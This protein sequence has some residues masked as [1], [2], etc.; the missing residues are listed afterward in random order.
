[1]TGIPLNSGRYEDVAATVS[2][3]DLRVLGQKDRQTGTGHVW[4]DNRQH[5]WRAVVNGTTISGVS[6]TV[7]IAMGTP[8][9][10]YAITWYDTQTGLPS[11]TETRSADGAGTLTLNVSDLRTDVAA[12]IAR[13]GQ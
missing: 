1:M 5:T 10:S 7:R 12:R 4:I 3:S 2:H 11:G 13:S 6:G 9:A 8:N